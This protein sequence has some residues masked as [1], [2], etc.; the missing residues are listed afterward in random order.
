MNI[1]ILGHTENPIH[2]TEAKEIK[3]IPH[4]DT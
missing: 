2:Q 4:I 1:K 3:Q